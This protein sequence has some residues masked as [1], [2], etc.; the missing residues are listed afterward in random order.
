MN[1]LVVLSLEDGAFHD[2]G[3]VDPPSKQKRTR[4][5]KEWIR[6]NGKD[7]KTY[8][9]AGWLTPAISCVE[10][11]TMEL[12]E[13]IPPAEKGQI[14]DQPDP[15]EQEEE[16]PAYLGEVGEPDFGGPN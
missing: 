4:T 9:L 16:V 10:T 6:K 15:P 3:T 2:A 12:I 14:V 1:D 11:K 13:R 7:G 5:L 8:R